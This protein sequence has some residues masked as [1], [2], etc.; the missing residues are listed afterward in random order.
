MAGRIPKPTALRLVEAGGNMRTRFKERARQE[1]RPRSPIGAPPPYFSVDQLEVWFR[2]IEAAPEGLLTGC[3]R[4]IFEGFVVL[5]AAR[6]KLCEQ[7][8]ASSRDVIA[9]SPDDENRWILVAS[10]REFKRLTESLRVLSHEL[11]FTPAARTRV[12]LSTP[13]APVD[14]LAEFMG[15]AR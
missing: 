6:A 8:N 13:E 1:P 14:P 3:D 7:Y 5:A 4:D 15:S 12:Q 11:G 9:Q 2:L 10:L